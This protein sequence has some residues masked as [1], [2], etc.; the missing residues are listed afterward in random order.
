MRIE[1][2]YYPAGHSKKSAAVLIC[3]DG[4]CTLSDDQKVL[5]KAHITDFRI[6][7]RLGDMPRQ[8]RFL[9]GE[10]FETEANDQVDALLRSNRHHGFSALLHRLES[11]AAYILPLLLV[12]GLSLWFLYAWGL[13]KAAR[14]IAFSLPASELNL[15][16]DH[17]LETLDRLALKPSQLSEQRKQGIRAR[18]TGLT[19]EIGSGFV[20]RLHFR[21]LPENAADA[22]ALPDGSIVVMDGLVE[23][24]EEP[25]EIDSILLH[26]IAHV[27][28]R[29]GLQSVFQDTL[30]TLMVSVM[31][32]DAVSTAQAA[33][34]LPILLMERKYSQNFEQQADD[35]ASDYMLT[36]QVDTVHFSNI[37]ER[38]EASYA[39]EDDKTK[40]TEEREPE[41]S[42]DYFSTHPRTK[43]RLL[44][45]REK[46]IRGQWSD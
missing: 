40:M 31:L 9:D 3:E 1:G 38:L 44:R 42:W 13:P 45:I 16:G 10:L 2:F 37:L 12:A 20:Y 30:L 19:D 27:E 8:M 17:T 32:G 25:W 14:V 26:E 4:R 22:F 5:F 21:R 18:F 28:E 29:H 35:Y 33:A 46:M 11:K 34:S 43:D 7:D 23:L 41:S 36:H 24:S 6:S 15:I 39:T